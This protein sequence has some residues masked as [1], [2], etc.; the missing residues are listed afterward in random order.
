MAADWEIQTALFTRLTGFAG[1]TAELANGADSVFDFVPQQLADTDAEFPY[2][3]IGDFE[4]SEFD[5][6]DRLGYDTTVTLH[7]FS[8][9]EGK[10]ECAD[11][12]AQVYDALHRY[13]L[14]V[15]GLNL[16]DCQWDGLSTIILDPDGQTRHGVQRFRILVTTGA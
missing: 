4:S 3:V 14:P 12:M 2:L 11:I 13:A 6:D 16:V 1:L 5:A 8:R 10:R 9:Y 7:T 15:A